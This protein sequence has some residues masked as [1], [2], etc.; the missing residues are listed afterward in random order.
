MSTDLAL[1]RALPETVRVETLPPGRYTAMGYQAARTAREYAYLGTGGSGDYHLTTDR[2]DLINESRRLYRNNGLYRAIIDVAVRNIIQGGFTFQARTADP[3]WNKEAEALFRVWGERPEV[4]DLWTWPQTQAMICSELLLAGDVAAL[5][6]AQPADKAGRLQLVEAERIDGPGY[7][8][9]GVITDAFGAPTAFN[10]CPYRNGWLDLNA[11]E[12][13]PA[14]YTLFVPLLDR[15][16]QTRGVPAAQSSFAMLHRLTDTCDSEALAYQL[17]ARFAIAFTR[18]GGPLPSDVINRDDPNKSGVSEE[19]DITTRITE[20]DK[21]VYF[22]GRTGEKIEGVNRNIPAQNFEATVRTFLRLA[23]LPV[24]LPLELVFLDFSQT[25]YSSARAS[26]EQAF[27]TFSA[28]QSL[29]VTRLHRPLWRWLA[30]RWTASGLL[31]RRDDQYAHEW[32][33]PPFPWLDQ[34][35]EAQAWGVKLDRGLAT[36][37]QAVK[38]VNGDRQEVVELRAQEVREAITTAKAIKAETGEAVPWQMFAGL[39]PPGTQSAIPEKRAVEGE[40]REPRQPAQ[41]GEP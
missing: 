24:G 20:T 7:G 33:C 10:V 21:G 34:L 37:S 22:W 5:E 2:K 18:E 3:G 25:N 1:A 4:R 26:L 15:P 28:R 13:K 40:P 36:Y 12:Q 11:G 16:S 27:G 38:S 14:A 6:L 29:L 9:N 35:K 41:D 17:L 23:G 19:G 30:D 39:Q 8:K 32:I 31:S